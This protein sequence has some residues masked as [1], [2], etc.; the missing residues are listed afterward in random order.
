[1]LEVWGQK[2]EKPDSELGGQYEVH[3]L[4]IS[5][6]AE[7]CS[8]PS[9][10]NSLSKRLAQSS[11]PQNTQLLPE[12]VPFQSISHLRIS[13]RQSPQEERFFPLTLLIFSLKARFNFEEP[14]E[15]LL[16]PLK[17]RYWW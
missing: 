6:M 7:N 2:G 4:R 14:E 13:F 15:M 16:P 3:Y 12:A 11:K 1:V 5:P 10:L 9:Q 8:Y 17:V